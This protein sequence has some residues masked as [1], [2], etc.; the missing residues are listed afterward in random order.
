MD[1]TRLAYI[2]PLG[3][4]TVSGVGEFTKGEPLPVPPH[5]AKSILAHWPGQFAAVLDCQACQAA[6]T[7]VKE[8]DERT[9]IIAEDNA[10]LIEHVK[11]SME[12]ERALLATNE[13][14]A[15]QVTDLEARVA[16][17]LAGEQTPP[18][19]IDPANPLDE[20]EAKQ[21]TD[22]TAADTP[23]N[24]P[25]GPP[26]EASAES[27]GPPQDPPADPPRRGRTPKPTQE[28]PQETP[29]E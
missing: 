9:A 27:A 22:A 20:P 10:R 4:K 7:Y 18:P 15:A 17:L 2:G 19:A 29:K 23:P 11:E 3:S 6:A 12:R 24:E 14:Q 13:R 8:A 26:A 5:K 28:V 25:G 1:I 21:V 16:A